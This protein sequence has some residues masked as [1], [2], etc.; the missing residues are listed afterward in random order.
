[1]RAGH[2]LALRI[3]GL[4]LGG[5]VCLDRDG[6]RAALDLLEEALKRR[7]GART[8]WLNQEMKRQIGICRRARWLLQISREEL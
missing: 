1:M 7:R 8:R 3:R 5:S 2:R 4:W 6:E